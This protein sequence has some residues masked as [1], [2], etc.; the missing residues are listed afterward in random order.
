MENEKSSLMKI[1]DKKPVRTVAGQAEDPVTH[2]DAAAIPDSED[3]PHKA[4]CEEITATCEKTKS[5]AA[6][7][8]AGIGEALEKLNKICGVAH[9]VQS[10]KKTRKR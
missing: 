5:S 10:A 4:T 2:T 3:E 6:G 9:V 1:L 8:R 7:L